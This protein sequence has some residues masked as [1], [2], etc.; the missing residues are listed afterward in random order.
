MLKNAALDLLGKNP[1]PGHH[2]SAESDEVI[3]ANALSE[4]SYQPVEMAGITRTQGHF[5]GHALAE[6]A[7]KA[8][9][10]QPLPVGYDIELELEEP[11][12]GLAT[13]EVG[14]QQDIRAQW[15]SDLERPFRLCVRWHR[16]SPP[17]S[18]A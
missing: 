11:R 13:P 6:D 7:V 9:L 4:P 2:L 10:A 3:V 17:L 14:D 1:Q 15:S 5:N 16:R 12:D 18:T 8:D